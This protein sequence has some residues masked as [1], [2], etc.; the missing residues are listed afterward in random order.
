MP[1]TELG[2]HEIGG[3][4]HSKIQGV[5]NVLQFKKIVSQVPQQYSLDDQS[6]VYKP[7]EKSEVGKIHNIH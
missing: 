5:N 4:M 3:P 2:M 7:R 6:P 1:Q